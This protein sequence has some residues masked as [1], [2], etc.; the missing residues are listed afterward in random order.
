MMTYILHPNK[1]LKFT[2]KDGKPYSLQDVVKKQLKNK[3]WS[4]VDLAQKTGINH[5]SLYRFLNGKLDMTHS[6]LFK[7]MQALGLKVIIEE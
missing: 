3:G 7:V 2:D 6:K 4:V 1:G 5:S